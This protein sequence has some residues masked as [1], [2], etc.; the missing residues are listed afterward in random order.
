MKSLFA[1]V[2]QLRDAVFVLIFSYSIFAIVGLILYEGQLKKRCINLDNGI[3]Y[4]NEVCSTCE[5]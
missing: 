4:D 1:S 3:N 2:L 5:I